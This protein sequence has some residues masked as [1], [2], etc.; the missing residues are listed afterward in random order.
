MRSIGVNGRESL[1]SPAIGENR[2]A[3]KI[4][5]Q[6]KM[7]S[8]ENEEASRLSYRILVEPDRF[9]LLLLR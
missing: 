3:T 6:S 7:W 9:C 1:L 5:I 2:V 8:Y 4:V